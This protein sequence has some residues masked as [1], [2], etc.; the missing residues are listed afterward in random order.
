MGDIIDIWDRLLTRRLQENA[1]KI[2]LPDEV[3]ERVWQRLIAEHPE[4]EHAVLE[5]LDEPEKPKGFIR[6]WLDRLSRS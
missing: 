5:W 6:R 2:E 1:K 4:M 3:A